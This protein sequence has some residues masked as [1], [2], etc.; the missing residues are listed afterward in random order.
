MIW[1]RLHPADCDWLEG[2]GIN[3]RRYRITNRPQGATLE[4][5]GRGTGNIS[6][7]ATF[8]TLD[9]AKAVAEDLEALRK[10]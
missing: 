6:P 2:K 4:I 1:V 3:G 10:S 9:E 8:S 5:R 7:P